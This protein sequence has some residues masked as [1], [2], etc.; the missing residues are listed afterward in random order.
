MKKKNILVYLAVILVLAA[1]L[2]NKK[3]EEPA[4]N[5]KTEVEIPVR[6]APAGKA[7]IRETV[8]V[9][10]NV[11]PWAEVTVYPLVSGRLDKLNVREGQIV[12]KGDILAQID[13]EKTELAVKQLE[14]QLEAAVVKIENLK[15]DYERMERLYQEKVVAEKT[16]DDIKASLDI[17]RINAESL[18]SQIALARV[19]LRDSRISAPMGGIISRK[20][21]DEGEIVTE[22][23]MSK[24]APLVTIVDISRVKI[25]VP[26]GEDNLRKIKKGQKAEVSIDAYPDRKFT[27]QVHNIFPVMDTSTRTTSIEI[28]VNNPGNLLKPGMFARTDI[29]VVNRGSV[30]AVPAE[31]IIEEEEGKIV[32][33]VENSK[34]KSRKIT[35]G[36]EEDDRVEILSGIEEGALLIVE[37]QHSVRNGTKVSIIE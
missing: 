13:Y 31:V 12:K 29:I 2:M 36:M 28:L 17:S 19:K 24:S 6:V 14:S 37:G 33:T 32:Y 1:L 35:T 27:G 18:R 11:E 26:V 4:G 10:G 25:T 20:Y 7:E 3:K 30:I 23:S 22:S 16:L 34:A 9:S 8:L 15:K 21:I 5:N